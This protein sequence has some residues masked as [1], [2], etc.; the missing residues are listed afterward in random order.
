[1]CTGNVDLR[2]EQVIREKLHPPRIIHLDR[3]LDVENV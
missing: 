2:K 3:L 1:M